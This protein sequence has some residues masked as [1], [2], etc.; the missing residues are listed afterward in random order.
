MVVD[1]VVLCSRLIVLMQR[2][3][4]VSRFFEHKLSVIPKSLFEDKIMQN[5][6]KSSLAKTL[7][8]SLQKFVNQCD[9]KLE[10]EDENQSEEEND[11]NIDDAMSPLVESISENDEIALDGGSLL[12]QMISEKESTFRDIVSINVHYVD[13]HYSQCTVVFDGYCENA[14]AKYHERKRRLLKAKVTPNMSVE[15][16]SRL[17]DVTQKLFLN[18]S[19]NKQKFINLLS[20]EIELSENVVVQC[21]GDGDIAT[22]S[23]VLIA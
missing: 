2:Y 17:A 16:K 23:K 5:P 15:L 9:D 14:S 11:Y 20:D 22:V 4:N 10:G 21:T 19:K 13:S 6:W 8:T 3:N 18:N 7:D 12:H 1:P